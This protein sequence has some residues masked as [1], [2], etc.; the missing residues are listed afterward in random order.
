MKKF[1]YKTDVKALKK[2]LIEHDIEKIS[3]LSEICGVSKNVLRNILNKSIQPST[4]TMFKLVNALDI[5][6]QQASE[7][8]FNIEI[9]NNDV[10]IKTS[11]QVKKS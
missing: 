9:L 2:V 11:E 1:I 8:F 6:P 7:I 4:D 10:D 3:E 5:S